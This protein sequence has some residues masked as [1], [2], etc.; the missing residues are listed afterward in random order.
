MTDSEEKAIKGFIKL[1][2]FSAISTALSKIK[3][4]VCISDWLFLYDVLC[5]I[6]LGME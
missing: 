2:N 5:G 1:E 6:E 4:P 3:E